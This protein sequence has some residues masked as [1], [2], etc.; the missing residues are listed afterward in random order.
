VA[1]VMAQPARVEAPASVE[2]PPAAE[3]RLAQAPMASPREQCRSHVL[4]AWYRCVKRAC[5]ASP[6][7]EGTHECQRV[8][9][10]EADN[11]RQRIQSQ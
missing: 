1:E 4:L 8:R 7:L 3:T 6:G 5:Q 9:Q 2:P 11:A 10:I